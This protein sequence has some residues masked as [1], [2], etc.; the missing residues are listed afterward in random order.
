M[1]GSWR[2]EKP[3]RILRE[4]ATIGHRNMPCRSGDR[5]HD[6]A[7]RRGSK[8]PTTGARTSR[9]M[10]TYTPRA[11]QQAIAAGVKCIDHGQLLDDATA[12]MMAEKGIW[13][14]LRPFTDDRP[15]T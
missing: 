1:G 5:E 8:R 11:V 14:S 10:R 2:L 13:W 9:C 3:G 7:F 12:K 4:A 15:S 6:H